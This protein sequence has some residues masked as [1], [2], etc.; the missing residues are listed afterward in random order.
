[1]NR[2]FPI[3]LLLT[4]ATSISAQKLDHR[5]SLNA[6]GLFSYLS[7]YEKSRI[8]G[9]EV[10][11]YTDIIR[12]SKWGLSTGLEYHNKGGENGVPIPNY[13]VTFKYRYHQIT[14]PVLASYKLTKRLSIHG[15][16]YMG[17]NSP[18]YFEYHVNEWSF[19]ANPPDYK[20]FL[21]LRSEELKKLE[22][23]SRLGLQFQLFNNWFLGFYANHAFNSIYRKKSRVNFL[24]LQN[25]DN[26]YFDQ[27][28]KQMMDDKLKSAK[29]MFYSLVLRRNLFKY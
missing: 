13:D 21:D 11:L 16:L 29:N 23:G 4:L 20:D 15:G 27:E 5:V 8:L 7:E 1:M 26:L 12:R 2:I 18:S 9:Y 28:F 10:G 24:F 3:I 19:G 25:D 6:G 17:Y 14:L 22:V